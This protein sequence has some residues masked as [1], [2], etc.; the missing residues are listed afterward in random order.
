[1]GEA[2][3]KRKDETRARSSVYWRCKL[4]NE[5]FVHEF[6]ERGNG[7]DHANRE[8]FG[9]VSAAGMGFISIK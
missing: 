2:L 4:E 7:G 3:L 8:E 1:M 9:W 6:Y 5:V